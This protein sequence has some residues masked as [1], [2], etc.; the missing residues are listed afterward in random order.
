[1]RDSINRRDFL[2]RASA[3]GLGLVL[4][5][6]IGSL[7]HAAAQARGSVR[8]ALGPNDTIRTAVIGTNGRGLAHIECLTSLPGV[9]VAYICDVDDRAIATGI[10]TATNRQKIEPKGLKDF[11]KALED[12]S[13]DAVTIAT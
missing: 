3:A 7:A 12:T 13:L 8:R 4:A 9:E 11:R 5:R 10:K 1:M 6:H 2:K